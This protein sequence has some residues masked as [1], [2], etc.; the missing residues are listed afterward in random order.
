MMDGDRP[1]GFFPMDDLGYIINPT[2]IDLIPTYWHPLLN[3]LKDYY[4]E[5]FGNDFRSMWIR[6]SLARGL[7]RKGLSDL[8]TFALVTGASRLRWEICR[9]TRK[10]VQNWKTLFPAGYPICPVELMYSTF[11]KDTQV[12]MPKISMLIK[13]QSTCWWG[14]DISADLAPVKPGPGMFLSHKW[15]ASDWASLQQMKSPNVMAYRTYIKTLIRTAF[16]L[17][18]EELGKFTPDLFWAVES[19]AQYYPQKSAQMKKILNL[20]IQ[21][22][23]KKQQL[24]TLL[25]EITPWIL[26]ESKRLTS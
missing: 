6:G 10:E 15:L 5:Q 3:A 20:Y 14:D 21:P 22:L 8:D 2:S 26:S 18:M 9:P 4:Q 16:E 23:D 11:D 1:G 12:E 13:T 7:F 24:T 17:V 25:E 19:F